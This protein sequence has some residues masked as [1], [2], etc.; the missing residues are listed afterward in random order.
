MVARQRVVPATTGR[1]IECPG[2]VLNEFSVDDSGVFNGA[3]MPWVFVPI[4]DPRVVAVGRG[5]RERHD[6]N[7]IEMGEAVETV[8]RRPWQYVQELLVAYRGH[9]RAS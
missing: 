2:H 1:L 5:L 9:Q 3:Q 6:V 8:S 7:D 4:R